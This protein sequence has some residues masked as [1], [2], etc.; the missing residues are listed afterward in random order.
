MPLLGSMVSWSSLMV[1]PVW[2]VVER[3]TLL[4]LRCSVKI[5]VMNCTK[6]S[7]VMW[8][9]SQSQR[10]NETVL[11]ILDGSPLMREIL[12]CYNWKWPLLFFSHFSSLQENGIFDWLSSEGFTCSSS[13]NA[14]TVSCTFSSPLCW[15]C[16]GALP[17]SQFTVKTRENV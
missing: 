16:L 14:C 7:N 4:D 6:K 11:V 9:L 13:E 5:Y 17:E 12:G 1:T 15:A 8:F 2:F 10:S 3:T